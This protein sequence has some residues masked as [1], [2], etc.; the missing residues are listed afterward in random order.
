[1]NDFAIIAAYYDEL[2]VKPEQYK[3]E[4][5][6]AM[7]L[8]ETY[9]LS[10][11]NELLDLA[12]GT[13]GH[14]TYWHDHYCV[15]GL[16][17]S[18]EMLSY[19]IRKFPDVK[20]HRGDM[21]DFTINQKFDALVCLYGS[22]GFIRTLENLKKTLIT[23]A[24]HM[25]PGGVLCLTPWSTQEEFKPKIVVDAVKHPN[26]RIARMENVKLKAPGLIV[27]D[28][29]H[30]IGRDGVVTYNT[31]SIEIGL[32]SRQQYID[33][34]AGAKLELMEY[35][36]GSDIPMGVFVARKSLQAKRS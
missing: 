22:I 29:H 32:F 35:Y 31:Q 27:V 24:A 20:F 19:A 30:L 14:I 11:G 12:C 15:T 3:I 34:I 13:G 4:A 17:I 25:N 18:P 8:I 2:Y 5:A 36:Q 6:K 21:V 26:V 7:A 10:G 23:F 28:F 16:D 9:K 1:M 33:A